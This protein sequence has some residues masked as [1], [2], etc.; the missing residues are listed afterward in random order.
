[1]VVS[2]KKRRFGERFKP[3]E[4]KIAFLG[5]FVWASH[6]KLKG[7]QPFSKGKSTTIVQ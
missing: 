3:L 7:V 1:M 4:K 5:M 6:L 2:D